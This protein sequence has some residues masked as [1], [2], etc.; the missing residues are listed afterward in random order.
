[1]NRIKQ[2]RLKNGWTQD[3]L[4]EK[5]CV[6]RSAVSKYESGKI[7]LTDDTIKKLVK[8]FNTS[9]DYILGLDDFDDNI[10]NMNKRSLFS[11]RL[12]SL[13]KERNLTQ[14]SLA[15]NLG[16]SRGQISNYEQGSRE[17]DQDTLLKIADFFDVSVDYLLG[18]TKIKNTLFEKEKFDLEKEAEKMIEKINKLKTIKFCGTSADEEDKEYLKLVSE[19]FLSDIRVYNKQKYTTPKKNSIE[20]ELEAYRAELEAEEKE[21]TLSALEKQNENLNQKHA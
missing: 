16:F 12:A 18:R 20:E 21:K 13:R 9:A 3:E 7:L 1:M 5:L 11:T 15:E 10:K 4:G 2:L 19:R 6:K 17:P 14:Y 8:I